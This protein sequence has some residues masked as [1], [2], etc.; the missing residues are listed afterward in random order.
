MNNVRTIFHID[1]NAFFCS[2]ELIKRPYLESKPFAVGTRYSSKGVLSTSNYVARKYGVHSAMSVS[3]AL[4]KCPNLIILDCDYQFYVE[5]SK[6]FF[7]IIYEYTDLVEPASIDEAFVDVS[8]INM[9]PLDFAKLLQKR[10]KDECNLPSSIGIAPTKFLAKMA[11]DMKKPMG[12]TVLRIRDIEKMLFPLDV[13][14]M[15]GIGK[16][17]APRLKELGINTIGDL[18]KRLE[19]LHDFFGDKMYLYVK[20]TLEGKSSNIVEPERYSNFSS[21]SNSRTSYEPLVN[22]DVIYEFLENVCNLTSSRLNRYHV[23][24]YT[25]T[26]T[27]KYTDLKSFSKSKT[28]NDAINDKYVFYARVKELFTELWDG[29]PIRLL[30]C[31]GSNLEEE[32]MK[33]LDLFHLD[34]IE[35]E[36]KINKALENI[37]DTYGKNAIKKGIK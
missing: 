20:R 13:S 23:K 28:Y 33:V 34:E 32:N 15:F 10:I 36:E 29:R 31:G 27:I 3:D 21:I 14:D 19:E 7:N 17:T 18:Y 37:E 5:C 24:A 16:K 9:H 26:V 12:I 6:K 35:K 2:C 8:E 4:K 1:M 30:G 11:S 25:I 22:E